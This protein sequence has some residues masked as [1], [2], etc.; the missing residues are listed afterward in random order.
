MKGP[1]SRNVIEYGRCQMMF[2]CLPH[3]N[4]HEWCNLT[5]FV[6]Q[7]SELHGKA[8]SVVAFPERENRNTKEP[9]VLLKVPGEKVRIAIERKSV[10]QPLDDRH[11]A[12]HRN[13]HYLFDGFLEQLTSRG[14]DCTDTVYCLEVHE[15]DLTDRRQ[16][17]VPKIAERLAA[18]VMRNWARINE[19]FQGIGGATPIPWRFRVLP[20]EERDFDDP[21]DGIVF[22]VN[23]IST[24]MGSPEWIAEERLAY[25]KEFER[26]AAS[27]ADKFV[28]YPDCRKLFLVQFFGDILGGVGDEEIIEMT[29]SARLPEAI[30]EVWVAQL[31]WVG[32]RESEIIWVRTR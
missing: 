5:G 15:R 6:S 17:E 28:Q 14:Y 18:V 24:L 2:S 27:A 11:M 8:Y 31:E 10:V 26:Q 32:L 4:E 16:K 23:L 21:E 22:K 7:Y 12:K 30:D 3:S 25:A 13:E 1:Y 29:K 20:S 19:S 9:E